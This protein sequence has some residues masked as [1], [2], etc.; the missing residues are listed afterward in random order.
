M[1]KFTQKHLLTAVGIVVAVTV[2]CKYMD[3]GG[4]LF[5]TTSQ[6]N[7]TINVP[8]QPT[9]NGGCGAG[10]AGGGCPGAGYDGGAD[11][12][13]GGSEFGGHGHGMARNRDIVIAPVENYSTC[14]QKKMIYLN[15][16]D[17]NLPTSHGDAHLEK[18]W[19]KLYITLNCNLPYAKGGVFH[20]MWGS[21]VSFLVDT[22]YKKSINLGSL[23]RHG[24]RYYKLSTE[25]LGDYGNYD[26]IWVYRQTEDYAPK[27][28]L[29][30]SITSQGCS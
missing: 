5:S 16:C 17:P 4:S 19:G 26:E 6:E 18:R 28:V 21:F 20:T 15:S 12:G 22:R 11:A 13:F 30:G 2:L 23:V 3:C 9:L 27:K 10:G 8:D 1:V 25:L 7:F 24:D 14:Y 29:V